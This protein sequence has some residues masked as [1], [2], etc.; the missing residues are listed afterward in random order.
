MY[1][2]IGKI[3]AQP[4]QREELAEILIH[5]SK[6]LPGCI[7]YVVAADPKEPDALWVTEVWSDEN[8]HKASLELESVKDAITRG[9][10]LIASFES[11]TETDPLGI[12]NRKEPNF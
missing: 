3:I 9:R 8:S 10:P 7:S 6:E 1:G 5:G 2:L 4:G 11:Q 12:N